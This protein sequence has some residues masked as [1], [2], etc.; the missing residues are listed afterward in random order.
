MPSNLTKLFGRMIRKL[1]NRNISEGMPLD[2]SFEDIK[3]KVE[4]IEARLNMRSDELVEL[5]KRYGRFE[6]TKEEMEQAKAEINR[7]Y[8]KRDDHSQAM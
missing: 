5:Y 1:S 6:I 4:S 2:E 3:N 7:K 8:L